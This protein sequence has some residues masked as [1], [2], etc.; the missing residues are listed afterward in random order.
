MLWVAWLGTS[1][2]DR[3]TTHLYDVWFAKISSTI[4]QRDKFTA[5]EE[6]NNYLRGLPKLRVPGGRRVSA[7]F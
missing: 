7:A 4:V 5:T 6:N 3:T 1:A 2:G